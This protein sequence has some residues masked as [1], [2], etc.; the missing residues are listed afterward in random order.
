M[1]ATQIVCIGLYVG[2][3]G[4]IYW[5]ICLNAAPY[6]LRY[7]LEWTKICFVNQTGRH[8]AALLN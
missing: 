1:A 3:A 2:I 4:C 6:M 7:K 5:V 8:M